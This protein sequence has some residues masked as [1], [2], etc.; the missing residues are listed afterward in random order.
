MQWINPHIFSSLPITE[1]LKMWLDASHEALNDGDAVSTATDL[2]GS[3]NNAVQAT[4]SAKPTYKTG[5][6]NGK[7][8]YRFDGGD[9]IVCSSLGFASSAFTIFVVMSYSSGNYP[10]LLAEMSGTS[11]GY[12]SLGGD[13]ANK[14]A[15]SKVGITTSASNLALT[16]GFLALTYKSAGVSGGNIS[17]TPYRNKVAGSGALTLSG[18]ST[19]ANIDIG[20]SKNGNA[21]FFT[22]DIA[23]IIVYNT[24]LSDANRELIEDYLMA[25]YA[26]S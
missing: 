4:P 24:Q 21:D 2:S 11:D 26:I 13:N 6:V 17:L 22:G 25:K 18:L 23:E 1:N 12:V 16:S 15:I 20:A 8:V 9:H 3:G 10:A 19:N 7:S 5:I 14:V